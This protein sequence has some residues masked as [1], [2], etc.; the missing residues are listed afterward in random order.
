MNTIN[1]LASIMTTM[2]SQIEQ[3][4][5]AAKLYEAGNLS[6][7]DVICCQIL[8][9]DLNNANALHLRGVIAYQFQNYAASTRLLGKANTLVKNNPNI[10]FAL[11]ASHENIQQYEPAISLYKKI[12]ELSPENIAARQQLA[13]VLEKNHQLNEA[14]ESYHI[15]NEATAND[16]MVLL[17]LARLYSN[18]GFDKK[19]ELYV[20]K[21]LPVAPN[22]ADFWNNLGLVYKKIHSTKNAIASFEKAL[23]LET[24]DNGHNHSKV[25]L[26]LAST[27]QDTGNFDRAKAH[28]LDIIR[29]HTNTAEELSR[30]YYNLALI[31]LGEGDFLKG[32]KNLAHR[33]KLFTDMP[34][35]TELTNKKLLVLGEEGLGDELTFLRFIPLLNRYGIQV[36]YISNKN[37]APLLRYTRLF[38][39]Q[40]N[41]IIAFLRWIYLIYFVQTTCR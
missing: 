18:F 24:T 14:L 20:E 8:K 37:L 4:E 17:A 27:L 15:L 2:A 40:Q 38:H 26:N 7:A 39:Q 19:A 5:T 36:D 16:P 1:K 35:V 22:D 13:G 33:P 9:K 6:E 28:Y 12:C 10:M 29:L 3:I 34:S 30:A 21:V 41:M 25:R 31:Y 11:A 32:W 23:S